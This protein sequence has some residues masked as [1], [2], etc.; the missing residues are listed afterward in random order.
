MA[1]QRF[2]AALTHMPRKA[3]LYTLTNR[4]CDLLQNV[5]ANSYNAMIPRQPAP[6]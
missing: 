4:R 3:G 1:P 6:P 2:S 5:M